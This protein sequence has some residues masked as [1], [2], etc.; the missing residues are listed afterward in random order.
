MAAVLIDSVIKLRAE[1]N[2][3]RKENAALLKTAPK[4]QQDRG[5]AVKKQGKPGDDFD[6]FEDEL[7]SA[8]KSGGFR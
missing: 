8:I 7:S 3:Q 4:T 6:E 2:A 5:E 1:L